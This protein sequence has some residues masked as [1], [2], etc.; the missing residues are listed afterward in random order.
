MSWCKTPATKVSSAHIHAAWREAID[1]DP[2]RAN[3]SDM[4]HIVRPSPA[5]LVRKYDLAMRNCDVPA[6]YTASA[7]RKA[8]G[9]GMTL[10]R[11]EQ[12]LRIAFFLVP[13]FSMM[14]FAAAVEPLRS[15]N[16]AAARPLFEWVLASVDGAPVTASNGIPVAVA[17]TLEELTKVPTALG[18][19]PAGVATVTGSKLTDA[20]TATS[21]KLADD[22]TAAVSKLAD[23][24]STTTATGRNLTDTSSASGKLDMIL[25]CSGLDTPHYPTVY[26]LLRRLSRHGVQVG[27]ISTGPFVLAE[28]GLLHG[29]RCTVHWEYADAF[30]A[31]YSQLNLTQDLYVIDND[32]LTCS[33]GTAALDM[34]LHI[35]KQ[36]AGTQLAM[37]VAEQF[38]HSRIRE[39]ED[40]QR[41]DLHARYGIDHPKLIQAIARMESS[42]DVPLEMTEIA[43]G[44]NLSIRQL[45]RLFRQYLDTSPQS[46]YRQQRLARARTLLRYTLTPLRMIA[47]DCGFEST[48]HFCHAYK[49][50]YGIPPTHERPSRELRRPVSNRLNTVDDRH[51][52]LATPP[53][54]LQPRESTQPEDRQIRKRAGA[55]QHQVPNRPSRSR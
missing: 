10:K 45:E 36:V 8:R 4:P 44:A 18:S 20:N 37:S 23:T 28:A 39:R 41:L 5:T 16:R 19:K 24:T 30:R 22:T 31:R 38:I 26:P 7:P 51:P 11:P 55:C 27:G 9:N 48:S 29:K 43:R 32:V 15:A 34:M 42:L 14:S 54:T 1:E 13:Q 25:V 33:G 17:G 49:R 46:F 3:L 52:T 21:G 40:H 53:I 2:C 35:V 47:L 12:P 50:V 6:C